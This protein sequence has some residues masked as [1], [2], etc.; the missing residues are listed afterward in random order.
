VTLQDLV[1]DTMYVLIISQKTSATSYLNQWVDCFV[2]YSEKD[3]D[4]I[5]GPG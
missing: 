1:K 5:T 4:F 2:S 3:F